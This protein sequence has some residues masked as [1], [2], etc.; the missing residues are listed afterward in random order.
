MYNA[1]LVDDENVEE[2]LQKYLTTLLE[3]MSDDFSNESL[4]ILNICQLFESFFGTILE[5]RKPNLFSLVD[6]SIYRKLISI[7]ESGDVISQHKG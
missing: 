2:I 1:I 5:G 7:F 6:A 4:E 3:M